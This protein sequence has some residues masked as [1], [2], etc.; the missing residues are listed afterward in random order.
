MDDP[1]IL[2]LSAGC[3]I[4][5][6]ICVP[7]FLDLIGPSIKRHFITGSRSEMASQW[8]LFIYC[9]AKYSSLRCHGE[10]YALVLIG[11]P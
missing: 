11:Y 1:R 5:F 7:A 4:F 2:V 6:F 8:F 3:Q 10:R 9:A